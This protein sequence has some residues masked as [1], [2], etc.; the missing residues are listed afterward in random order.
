MRFLFLAFVMT[1][2]TF[3]SPIVQAQEGVTPEVFAACEAK[4]PNDFKQQLA[5]VKEQ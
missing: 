1:A 3:F 5:C 4:T 2:N